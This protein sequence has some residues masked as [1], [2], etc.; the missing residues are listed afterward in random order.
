MKKTIKISGDDSLVKLKVTNYQDKSEVEG[1]QR[2]IIE[3]YS[4]RN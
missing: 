3:P 2:G 1:I 4:L